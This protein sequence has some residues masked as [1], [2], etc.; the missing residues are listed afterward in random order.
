MKFPQTLLAFAAP[1]AIFA[2]ASCNGDEKTVIYS[3]S[4]YGDCNEENNGDIKYDASTGDYVLC[5]DS[6][7]VFADLKFVPAE[8]SAISSSSNTKEKKSSSSSEKK[9]KSSSSKK[10]KSSS[11]EST[12]IESSSNDIK[13]SSAAES[14]DSKSSSSSSI[15]TS[16]SAKSSSSSSEK[17]KKKNENKLPDL[18]FSDTVP[19]TGLPR[20]IIET[21]DNTPIADKVTDIPA[22]LQVFGETEAETSVY[23]ITIRGRGN[24]TWSYSKKPYTF[25]FS[26]KE[27]LLGMPKAKKWLMIANFRDRTLIKNALSLE[28][29]RQ[30]DYSWQ[31]HGKYADVYLNKAFIGNYFICEKIQVQKNRLDLSDEGYLLEFDVNYDENYKFKS[32]YRQLP[33]N[34]A[35]PDPVTMSQFKYIQNYIDTLECILAHDKGCDTL[36]YNNYI[37]LKSFADYWLVQEISTNAEAVH[38]K[39]VYIYKDTDTK[40]MAGP[41]WD[42]DWGTYNPNKS[43]FI[44]KFPWVDSLLK[45]QDFIDVVKLEWKNNVNKLE[46]LDK[47]IDSIADYTKMSND[48]NHKKWPVTVTKGVI[49]DERLELDEAMDMLRNTYRKRLVELGELI[50]AL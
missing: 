21:L 46:N 8:D 48:E 24:L 15:T 44:G 3:T 19:Y 33:I 4:M 35:D 20:I 13:T 30:F 32:K 36:D 14:S 42:F 34:I 50:D 29:A 47:F 25:N 1:L 18:V 28:I 6:V 49:G 11:S 40:L 12:T 43:G 27:S 7:W 37:D 39:S 23:D 26:D 31:S 9:V 22:R 5:N 17:K 38:P 16:S 45:R 41:A 10:A 2:L